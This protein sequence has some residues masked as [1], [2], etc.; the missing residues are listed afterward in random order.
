MGVAVQH[1][2]GRSFR[3]SNRIHHGVGRA[4]AGDLSDSRKGFKGFLRFVSF[5]YHREANEGATVIRQGET[6]A[7]SFPLS[8]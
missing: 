8:D 4:K 6:P 5:N 3:F 1:V 2:D 7:P